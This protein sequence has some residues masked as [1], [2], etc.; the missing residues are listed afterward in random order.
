MTPELQETHNISLTQISF[1]T[2]KE[3]DGI[4]SHNAATI[5]PDDSW[6]SV[7]IE[8]NDHPHGVLQ[9]SEK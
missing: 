3:N 6:R 2:L 4:K 8:E 1:T 7:V 9:V 5:D